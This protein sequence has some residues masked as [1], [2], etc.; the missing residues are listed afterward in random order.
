MLTFRSKIYLTLAI[1]YVGVLVLFIASF[2]YFERN[3]IIQSHTTFLD[4]VSLVLQAP[5]QFESVEGTQDVMATT[6]GQNENFLWANVFNKEGKLF[7]KYPEDAGV[8]DG[9]LSDENFYEF[10]G[11]HKIFFHRTIWSSD[12]S[13]ILGHLV[14]CF[15]VPVLKILNKILIFTLISSFLVAFAFLIARNFLKDG[16]S[17]IQNLQKGFSDLGSGNIRQIDVKS[18]DEFG[19]IAEIWNGVASKIREVIK[20]IID[21]SGE[22]S[23]QGENLSSSSEQIFQYISK[24]S[25]DLSS[26]SNAVEE[27]SSVINES[28]KRSIDVSQKSDEMFRFSVSARDEVEKVRLLVEDFSKKLGVIV[29]FSNSLRDYLER[30]SSVTDTIEDIADQTNL[31]ALNASI[32][33]ARAGEQGKGFS[34]V[35]GEIR[36]LAEKT[37]QESKGIKDL[38]S[39]IMSTWSNLEKYI[40]DIDKVFKELLF[41]F[42][43][44]SDTYA[45]VIQ[46]TKEQKDM[47][48]N[49]SSSFEEQSETVKEL[50]KNVMRI[51]GAMEQIKYLGKELTRLSQK[52]KDISGTLK[53]LI[54]FFKV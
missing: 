23:G 45:L 31:L 29:D 53:E 50:S 19:K 7:L 27:F 48:T 14:V 47:I 2:I 9:K 41:R 52:L 13:E 39:K 32:E 12:G 42:K 46:R 37:L 6:L 5:M 26:V 8:Y 3:K 18:S 33:A 10:R 15:G 38:I 54:S 17:S 16:L 36:K 24:V 49:L 40:L 51:T 28:A 1:S 30:I 44:F 21:I 4:A 11:I 25:A 43:S 35:A 34:V 20:S 22:V